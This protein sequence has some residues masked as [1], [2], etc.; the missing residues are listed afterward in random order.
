MAN[1]RNLTRSFA[2]GE[3]APEVWGR[4]DLAKFQSGLATC[5]NFIPLPHGP[6]INRSGFAFVRETK[7]SSA[8][9]R[10][11]SFSYNNTQTFAIEVGAGYF[12]W[13]T[14]GAVLLVGSVSAWVTATGYVIGD[15][16]SNGGTNYY[17]TTAHTSGTFATDLAAGK[18]YALPATGEYEIPNTYAAADLFDIHY[19]QSADVLTLVHPS[20]PIKELRR[21]GATDWRLSAPTFQAPSN[22][23]TGVT[24]TATVGTGTTTFQYQVTAVN[25]DGLEESVA[26]SASASIT[27]NLTTAGNYN[28]V[29]WT[30]PATGT[31]IRYNVYKLSNGLYGY[32]GQAGALSFKDDNIVADVTKTPPISDSG[33]NDATGNYPGA[34]SYYEQRRCFG[35]TNNKPQNMWLTRS[36]T[37]SNL[38]YTIP[39]KDDNRIAF[40]IA[41]REAS[42]IRHIVPVSNLMLLTAS[43]EWRINP[44]NSD[45]LTP[46]SV[47][48]RPQSYIGANNV[49]PVVIGNSVIFAQSRGGRMREMSYNWQAQGY[50]SNDVSILAPHLF[51]YLTITDMAYSKAPIPIL[52]AVSSNGKLLGMT[53]VPEQQVASWHQHD[54]DGTFESICTISESN[55]D[56]LYAIVRRTINGTTKRYVEAMHTREFSTLADAY[57]VDCGGTY[58]GTPATTISGLTWLEGKTVNILAD[59]AVVPPQVVT[60]G[61][62]TLPVAASKVQV[63]LPITSDI[64]TL[65][66]AAGIDP[67]YGQGREKNVNHVWL[68]TYRSSGIL[69]GPSLTSM[70]PYKQRTTETYGS[71]PNLVSDEI[72]IV[73]SPAWQWGGQVYVR[74]TEPLPLTLVSMTMELSV[75]G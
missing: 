10:L 25:T 54:T 53:Y 8:V 46:T 65:P 37:E 52:W 64:V 56:V 49:T 66:F 74:Q 21:Y 70:V 23:P 2:S 69:A 35:G 62:I 67:A 47:S 41:A 68:R 15:L 22:C 61:A 6:V 72:E 29:T 40:R 39:T 48:V 51:D 27:N 4:V 36:G 44:V 71:A 58:S 17:C 11:I 60:G 55:N 33:F 18:W 14:Q 38:S 28:T 63:G 16:R 75:G 50:L 26:S 30:A 73:L 31:I 12:R 24:A 32:I 3:M 9:S 43:C 13:H 19:V 59:G 57:F 34:V 5:R 42:A 7:T 20:Y 45:A 1:V